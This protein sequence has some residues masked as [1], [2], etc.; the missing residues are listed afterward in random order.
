M[1]LRRHGILRPEMFRDRGY[2]DIRKREFGILSKKVQIQGYAI[3]GIW[4]I[5]IFRPNLLGI[6]NIQTLLMGPDS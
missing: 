5:N 4:D 2:L 1:Q 6:R 3:K